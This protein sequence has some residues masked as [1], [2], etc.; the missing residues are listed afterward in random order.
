MSISYLNKWTSPGVNSIIVSKRNE[1]IG[2]FYSLLFDHCKEYGI[3]TLDTVR[4]LI[5]C[6]SIQSF[7]NIGHTDTKTGIYLNVL[8]VNKIKEN[9]GID[10]EKGLDGVLHLFE[11][12]GII[13]RSE[14]DPTLIYVNNY[15]SITLD[16]DVLDMR[17][18]LHYKIY[19][20][21]LGFK[22][23]DFPNLILP[24][25]IGNHPGENTYF[26][27]S[28]TK[29]TKN[30]KA[31]KGDGETKSKKNFVVPTE[32]ELQKYADSINFFSFDPLRFIDFYAS[33][34]WMIGKNKMVNWKAAVR[35]WQKN[36]SVVDKDNPPVAP[37][38][39]YNIS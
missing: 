36:N 9:D 4:L 26:S 19:G 21:L 2:Y 13:Q 14:T 37:K 17:N 24:R 6:P 20:S 33:K 1:V 3:L 34:G 39:K 22:Y 7:P 29:A 10:I 15:L 38:K 32:T 23:N 18:P 35:T 8:L 30:T 25:K 11:L 16:T 31:S 28:S 12:F 27:L 5:L